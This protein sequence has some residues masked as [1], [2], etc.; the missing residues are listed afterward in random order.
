M[1]FLVDKSDFKKLLV[2]L[3]KARA[4]NKNGMKGRK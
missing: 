4:I 3:R 2:C 1:V